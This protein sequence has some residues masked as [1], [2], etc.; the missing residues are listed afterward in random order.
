MNNNMKTIN[1]DYNRSHITGGALL[2]DTGQEWPNI[3]LFLTSYIIVGGDIVLRAVRNI[4]KGK[5]S[6]RI[7]LW[8]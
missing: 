6:T 4:T 1:T 5:V 8:L 2:I 3:V 7:S